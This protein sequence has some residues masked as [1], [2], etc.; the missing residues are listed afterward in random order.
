MLPTEERVAEVTALGFTRY[1][2]EPLHPSLE[3][4]VRLLLPELFGCVSRGS[5][6]LDPFARGVRPNWKGVIGLSQD[7]S[8]HLFV[9]LGAVCN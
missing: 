5:H 2:K 7:G 4:P 6:C 9:L 1:L 3:R 8:V